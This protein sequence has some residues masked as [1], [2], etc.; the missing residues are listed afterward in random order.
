VLLLILSTDALLVLLSLLTSRSALLL[1]LSHT[2]YEQ[3]EA[4]KHWYECENFSATLNVLANHYADMFADTYELDSDAREL[5]PIHLLAAN[6]GHAG[7]A[8]AIQVLINEHN[9]PVDSAAGA[10]DC[11]PAWF[12][13]G[14]ACADSSS[15]SSE[16][17]LECLQQL[18]ALGADLYTTGGRGLLYAA[19]A[20]GNTR[21]AQFLFDKGLQLPEA[22]AEWF[23]DGTEHDTP[24]HVAAQQGHT[25]MVRLLLSRGAQIGV[26]NYLMKTALRCCLEA[27][28][29]DAQ[30]FTLLV[31]SGGNVHDVEPLGPLE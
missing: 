29:D 14:Y 16:Y 11:T 1:K 20:S 25:A 9:I 17:T 10:Q 27:P 6:A 30:L 8:A 31:A 3:H 23:A 24:L 12:A 15:S 28:C 2:H 4:C 26:R 21:A 13:A 22:G 7:V 19:A 18:L 5:A